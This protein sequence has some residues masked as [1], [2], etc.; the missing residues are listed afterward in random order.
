MP[1]LPEVE[2]FRR[3][4]EAH[5]LH[6]PIQRTEIHEPRLL[7][8]ITADELRHHLEGH[9]LDA[10]HRHGKYLFIRLEH[11]PWLVLHFG[12]SGEPRTYGPQDP[13]PPH[14]RL[15]LHFQDGGHLAYIDPRKLGE[16]TLTPEPGHLIHR[17]GLGPDALETGW[18]T[19]H[20]LTQG[21]RGM[22]KPWLMDQHHIA[23]I[24]NIYSDE[25]LFQAGIHPR[26]PL[27][28]LEETR[29]RRLHHKIRDT[30]QQAI[31]AQA[32]P[33]RLPPHFL[34]PHRRPGGRCPRCHATLAH[35]KINGR[36]SWYCPRCQ[37]EAEQPTP[38]T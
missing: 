13:P 20:R 12:M 35:Q 17:K 4:I 26:H 24:G 37:P 3:H 23:G 36:T 27:P 7:A 1:E 30:L 21:Q 9:S 6:R 25:I 16:I 31:A 38:P 32:D 18:T 28:R 15:I 29:L 34:I 5:A 11:G 14:A 2:T 33:T 22:I 10:T 19:F 8:D